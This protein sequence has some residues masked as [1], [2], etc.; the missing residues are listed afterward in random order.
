MQDSLVHV[1][2]TKAMKPHAFPL[3]M[4]SVHTKSPCKRTQ[5]VTTLLGPTMLVV[6]GACW[7]SLRDEYKRTQQLPTLLA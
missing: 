3:L 6:V 5:Q 2:V 1:R 7:H 4:S